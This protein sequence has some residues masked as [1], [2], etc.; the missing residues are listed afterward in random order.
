VT[1]G[2]A[3]DLALAK[4]LA[5]IGGG[6]AIERFRRIP[7]DAEARRGWVTEADLAAEPRSAGGS[8]RPA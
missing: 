8:P 4:E 6:E 2:W 1:D 5:V 7:A 3:A